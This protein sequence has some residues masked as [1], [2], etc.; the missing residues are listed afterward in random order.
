MATTPDIHYDEEH[1]KGHTVNDEPVPSVTEILKIID[2]SGPLMWWAWRGGLASVAERIASGI[3]IPGD[4]DKLEAALKRDKQTPNHFRNKA[5]KRG[6]AVH[7]AAELWAVE[8][9]VPNPNEFPEEERGYVQALATWIVEQQP[10]FV[11]SEIPVG[12][13]EHGFIGKYDFRAKVGGKLVLGDYKTS[14][15]IYVEHFLQLSA[16]ELASI[17]CGLGASEGQMVVRLG[18]DGSYE[19]ATGQFD[20]AWFLAIKGAWDAH[21]AAKEMFKKVEK[22]EGGK[23]EDE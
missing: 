13:A 10:E 5:A 1:R 21:R 9:E 12:S 15:G 14:K 2:K 17:E 19:Q 18:A 23:E 11:D 16:Y 4:A 8:G 6:T 22:V 7:D 20:P 3:T